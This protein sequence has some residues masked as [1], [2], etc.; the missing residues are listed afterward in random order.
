M[1]RGIGGQCYWINQG[2]VSQCHIDENDPV[3]IT[4]FFCVVCHMRRRSSGAR[5]T[6]RGGPN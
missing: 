3:E 5:E 4:V 1:Q 6:E 2:G